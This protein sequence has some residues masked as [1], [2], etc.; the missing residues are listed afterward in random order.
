METKANTLGLQAV[1][2][3]ANYQ[4]LYLISQ[5]LF[6]RAGQGLLEQAI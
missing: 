6:I 1:G 4:K 2:N 3:K 5:I